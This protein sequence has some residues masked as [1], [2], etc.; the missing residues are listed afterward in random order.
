MNLAGMRKAFGSLS[1]RYERA[2]CWPKAICER[3]VRTA[4][5]GRT[6]LRDESEGNLTYDVSDARYERGELSPS[7]SRRLTCSFR[8][9]ATDFSSASFCR[10]ELTV[11]RT[12]APEPYRCHWYI[13]SRSPR[14]MTGTIET[15][16][17][18]RRLA[19]RSLPDA[20]SSSL[21]TALR[22]RACVRA[23]ASRLRDA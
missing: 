4:F 7:V 10:R 16:R 11:T 17:D 14:S 3:S 23:P 22:V 8:A 15:A 21:S 18:G 13:R 20:A 2:I 1:P 6:G 12:P 9:A 5:E 19:L